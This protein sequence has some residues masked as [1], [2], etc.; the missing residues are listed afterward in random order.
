MRTT[1]GRMTLIVLLFALAACVAASSAQASSGVQFGIQDDAWL[2]FGPGNARPAAGD[3]R[4][5][6]RA[7]RPLH[8]ALEPDRPAAAEGSRPRRA[9]APTTGIG[10]DRI[11]RGLR[12]H[13]LT[14]VLTLVGTPAWANGGR[15]PR[16]APPRPTRLPPLRDRR[17]PSL[18]VGSL[19]ADLERAEQAPLA[20]ADEGGDLRP[21]PAQ[22]RVRGDPRRAA[23]RPRRRR[24]D[25]ARGRGGRRLTRHLGPRHGRRPREARR[26]RP[27]PV[28]RRRRRRRRPAAAART[29]P[30]SRWRRSGSSSSS[31][32]ATSGRSRSG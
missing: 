18:S 8:A 5:A 29:A 31:S 11:L 10:P 22:P 17:R 15:A 9:I 6:R 7:A 27:P 30:G 32:S 14:P 28:P 25:R 12:R 13:G 21:A 2:E 4:A 19:L 23:A 26:L 24:R 3:V 1:A 20:Q 16:F